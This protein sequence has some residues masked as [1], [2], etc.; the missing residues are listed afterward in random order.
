MTSR[1]QYTE[2]ISGHSRYVCNICFADLFEVYSH[3]VSRDV[4]A[5]NGG[6]ISLYDSVGHICRNCH[7]AIYCKT[8]LVCGNI[9]K[10]H[11]PN[12]T[13]ICPQCKTP[14]T[15]KLYTSF[16]S[17]MRRAKAANLTADLTFA[18]LLGIAK[19]NNYKCVYCGDRYECLDHIQPIIKG[20]G[21][22]V[23]NIT[24]AC[25]RCNSKKGSR[26]HE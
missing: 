10:G 24:T 18:E 19:S 7:D 12:Q 9:F 20:G 4:I 15:S 6:S 16:K 22:T 11:V 17:A 8:C 5:A 25:K 3:Y 23:T 2:Q 1:Y 21:T 26:W 14:D 13:P